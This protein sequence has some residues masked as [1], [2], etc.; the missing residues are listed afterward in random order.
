MWDETG[1]ACVESVEAGDGAEVV[2]LVADGRVEEV[3]E[4]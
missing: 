3:R 4:R 2:E 1:A